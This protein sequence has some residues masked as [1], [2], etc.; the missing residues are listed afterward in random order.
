MAVKLF[1]LFHTDTLRHR[2]TARK[3]IE[4]LDKKTDKEE[5][6]DFEKIDFASRSFLHELLSDL[7]DRKVIFLNRNNEIKQMMEIAQKNVIP[8]PC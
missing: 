2:E 3:V 4:V 6:I 7:G 5:T 8:L 1:D